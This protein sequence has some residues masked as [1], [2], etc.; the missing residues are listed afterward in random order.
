ME[1]DGCEE[2]LDRLETIIQMMGF[3]DLTTKVW[4]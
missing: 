1:G 2:N 4:I 3:S